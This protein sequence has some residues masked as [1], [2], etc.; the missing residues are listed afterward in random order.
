[1]HAVDVDRLK[2]VGLAAGLEVVGVARA[3]PFHSTRR[4][5]L[6]RKAAGLSA[7]MSFTYRNPARS[8][9]PTRVLPRAR[10]LVV[11]AY[12]Y[13]RRPVDKRAN[14][15]E[16]AGR[17]ARYAWEDHYASLRDALG[18]MAA[19]LRERGCRAVVVLDDNAL[20][21]REAAYR[22]G[23]GWYGKSTNLLLPGRGSWF[24]L[25]SVVTD[26]ELPPDEP[27]PD[28]CG[29]CRRC[30]DGCP[31]GAIVAP[32]MVDAR[33]CLAWL[34]QAP[35][36][37]P[38]EHRE[39]LGDRI[40]GCD[41]CQE[42]CPPNQRDERRFPAPEPGEAAEAWVGLLEV[43]SASDDELLERHGR[44][45]IAGR[46]PRWLRRNALVALGNVG[47]PTDPEVT[48]VVAR[49]LGDADP[50]LR[51]HALWAARRL[52]AHDL[53]RQ[54]ADDPAPEVRAEW[55]E[56][57]ADRSARPHRSPPGVRP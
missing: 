23:V 14:S 27:L 8:A 15:T 57:V 42:V 48:T 19:Y 18:A 11:G 25:G 20:V 53:A 36:T 43:L 31:T 12:A 51:A 47:E 40:Y 39:A 16:P 26:A 2:G 52:G 37:F 5:L 46:E 28:G 24:V 9:D 13:R 6:D 30:I 29:A 49:F 3:E 45:Y 55:D 41:D 44:W 17:V 21:D 56:A 7:G 1:V 22:A 10:S 38:H 50:V 54:L 35:G 34:V 32:G 33:R 4:D